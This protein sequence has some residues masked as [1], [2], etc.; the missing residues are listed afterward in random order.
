MSSR[1]QWLRLQIAGLRDAVYAQP[2]EIAATT[3]QSLVPRG[4]EAGVQIGIL[5]PLLQSNA[6]PSAARRVAVQL[7]CAALRILTGRVQPP[8]IP[9]GEGI[10]VG[11]QFPEWVLGAEECC[12]VRAAA[13]MTGHLCAAIPSPLS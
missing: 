7:R 11:V 2:S 6:V 12:V 1:E 9:V 10:N 8:S 5:F 13:A 3:G 4:M